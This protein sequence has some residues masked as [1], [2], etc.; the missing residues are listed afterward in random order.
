M[1]IDRHDPE[2]DEAYKG[3]FV[4]SKL[5]KSANTVTNMGLQ[6]IADFAYLNF[7][8]LWI[9]YNEPLTSPAAMAYADRTVSFGNFKQERNLA[10]DLYVAINTMLDDSSAASKKLSDHATNS[11]LRSKIRINQPIVKAWLEDMDSNRLNSSDAA[12][13]F[14]K[15]Q[16]MFNIQNMSYKNLARLAQDWPALSERERN[17]AMSRLLQYFR[18]HAQRAELKPMLDELALTSGYELD[19]EVKLDSKQKEE[20]TKALAVAAAA[21]YGGYKL[22]KVMG[23]IKKAAR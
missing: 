3:I 22:G 8:A 4:E 15:I 21:M 19:R 1:I 18:N 12:R 16:R 20:T 11:S 17:L 9:M 5:F 6:D 23:A 7:V 13:F 10:T 14:L 2:I